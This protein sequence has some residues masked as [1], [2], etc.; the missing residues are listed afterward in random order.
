[1]R[2][3]PD[4]AALRRLREARGLT[5]EELA[6]LA[7]INPMT[8]WRIE[9]GQVQR[10]FARTLRLLAAALDRDPKELMR[11]V[12]AKAP[13]PE[14]LAP[15]ELDLS[16]E[17][18]D[19][20]PDPA[21]LP[22]EPLRPDTIQQLY[23][24]HRAEAGRRFFYEARI[25]MSKALP[26]QERFAINRFPIDEA[27]C[28]ETTLSIDG[29]QTRVPIYT[30]RPELTDELQDAMDHRGVMRLLVQV[31][32]VESTDDFGTLPIGVQLP[33]EAFV[34]WKGFSWPS[35]EPKQMWCFLVIGADR[36][37]PDGE[38]TDP[39]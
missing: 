31:L 34:K 32:V 7:K 35:P 13:P 23:T 2:V 20:M 12:T 8:V 37:D 25:G 17:D 15:D 29:T 14:H 26:I 1:M 5:M 36:V 4:G 33:P 6:D 18:L 3:I 16:P 11:S 24:T 30:N 28:F 21:K 39:G 9:T 10:S 38:W 22:P 27:M 19:E